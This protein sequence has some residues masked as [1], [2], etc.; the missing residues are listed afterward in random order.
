SE[1]GEVEKRH[2][3]VFQQAAK[4]GV[5]AERSATYVTVPDERQR[6]EANRKIKST[7]PAGAS[8]C[9]QHGS[10]ARSLSL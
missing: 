1:L 9:S 7:L 6:G 5:T 2:D 4:S 3:G 10:S 8:L